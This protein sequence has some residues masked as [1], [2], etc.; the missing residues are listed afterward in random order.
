MRTVV[1]YLFLTDDSFSVKDS[2]L[3]AILFYPVDYANAMNV[4]KKGCEAYIK[5]KFELLAM[6]Q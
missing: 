5:T 1:A 4:L 6:L 3:T 2:S